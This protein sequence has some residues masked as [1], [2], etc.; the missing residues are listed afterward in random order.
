M[1]P[2]AVDVA[3]ESFSNRVVL[4]EEICLPIVDEG[5][6]NDFPKL[7]E[8]TVKIINAILIWESEKRSEGCA[9]DGSIEDVTDDVAEVSA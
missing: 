9:D 5:D 3:D 8:K 4:T 7:G 1:E 6:S 2:S